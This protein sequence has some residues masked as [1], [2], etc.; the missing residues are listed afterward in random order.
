MFAPSLGQI[1]EA[2][3]YGINVSELFRAIDLSLD[4][5]TIKQIIRK[6]YMGL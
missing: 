3:H 6:E 1:V 5:T 2:E 4:Q